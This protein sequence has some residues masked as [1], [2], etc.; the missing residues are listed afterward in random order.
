MKF[1]F[2]Q[3]GLSPTELI[4]RAPQGTV[5][6]DMKGLSPSELIHREPQGTVPDNKG[7]HP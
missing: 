7:A 4:H 6:D 2:Q 3:Q 5:P 1:L